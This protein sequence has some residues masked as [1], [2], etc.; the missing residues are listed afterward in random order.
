MIALDSNVLIRYLARDDEAQWR[1]ATAL[2]DGVGGRSRQFY[3]SSVV[4]A[5]TA[6]VLRR[7]YRLKK[8]EFADLLES[9]FETT[10][11][12]F[13][14]GVDIRKALA[15]YRVGKGDFADYLIREQSIAAGCQS[16]ATFDKDLLTEAYF[17]APSARD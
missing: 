15:S 3:V 2:I 12:Q 6:W 11:F 5:E 13:S 8:V 17:V 10:E 7:S 9:I 4:L 16:M 14:T 1:T